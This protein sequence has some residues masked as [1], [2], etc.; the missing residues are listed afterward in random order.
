MLTNVVGF[1][2]NM[3]PI[4]TVSDETKTFA[5][6]LGQLKQSPMVCLSL[7]EVTYDSEDIVA[8]AKSS[9]SGPSAQD[10]VA[11]PIAVFDLQTSTAQEIARGFCSNTGERG[12][13]EFQVHIRAE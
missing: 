9:S 5:G 7:D 6:Y 10:W 13:T 2:A 11:V 1:F 8:Q 3:L 12:G 4:K